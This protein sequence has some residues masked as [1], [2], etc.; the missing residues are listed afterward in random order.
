MLDTHGHSHPAH[1]LDAPQAAIEV[2]IL[3][4]DAVLS[5]AH[6]SPPRPYAIGSGDHAPVDFVVGEESLGCEQLPVVV[7]Q[8]AGH[9]LELPAGAQGHVLQ[10]GQWVAVPQ[11]GGAL[12]AA[13]GVRRLPLSLGTCAHYTYGG[14]TLF[15]RAVAAGRRPVTWQANH[16]AA[17]CGRTRTSAVP[18]SAG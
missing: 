7:A 11:S 6:L 3:W 12:A 18:A 10:D 8:G 17:G 13:D 16:A 4:G 14:L 9:A 1:E 5:V 15:V 2:V